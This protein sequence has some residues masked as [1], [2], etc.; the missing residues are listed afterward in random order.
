MAK[1]VFCLEGDWFG[2]EDRTT[3]EPVLHLLEKNRYLEVPYLHYNVA[4]KGE[5]KF[6]LKE[7]R[8]SSN[9]WTE[10]E[11]PWTYPILYLGFHG[12]ENTLGLAGRDKVSLDEIEELLKDSCMNRVIFFAS[13]LT[14]NVHG[15]R[16]NR[17]LKTTKAF[18]ICGY[19]AKIDWL[20]STI[21]DA[22]F[23]ALL[24]SFPFDQDGRCEL[25]GLLSST[26][27]Q[28]EL[29]KVR[30][31]EEQLNKLR[32]E[33]RRRKKQKKLKKKIDEI[34]PM[35]N[36]EMRL[37]FYKMKRILNFYFKPNPDPDYPGE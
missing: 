9:E 35:R 11:Y 37:A 30:E 1:G 24:Q 2:H 28:E 6:R 32:N 23:L 8:D 15:H 16:L 26:A 10:E 20:V 18:A 33:E 25:N 36:L 19:R 7:W 13:C 29:N 14:L 12:A 4:T 17:F 21:F 3:V 22:V 5:F 31:L 27:K 34:D